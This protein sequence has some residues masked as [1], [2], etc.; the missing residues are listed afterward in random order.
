MDQTSAG[1]EARISSLQQEND[2][3]EQQLVQEL[4]KAGLQLEELRAFYSASA[5]SHLSS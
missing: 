2:A 4:Q 5:K 3:L 1:L